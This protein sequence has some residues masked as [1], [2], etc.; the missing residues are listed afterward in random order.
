MDRFSDAFGCCLQASGDVLEGVAQ[1]G[2]FFGGEFALAAVAVYAGELVVEPGGG[3]AEV[4]SCDLSPGDYVVDVAQGDFHRWLLLGG[5]V[6][7]RVVF[8]FL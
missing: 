6:H 8:C 2:F 7:G 1:E 4:L 3:F 5:V